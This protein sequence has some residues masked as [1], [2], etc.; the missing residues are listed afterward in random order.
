MITYI[1]DSLPQEVDTVILAVNYRRDQ[2]QDYIDNL[3]LKQK[4]IVNQ[5][6]QPLGTGGATK[7]A[8]QYLTSD[9]FFVLNADIIASINL[10]H[11]LKNHIMKHAEA[12]I[13]LWPVENVSEYGVV[14]I[15]DTGKIGY[16][17]EK[18][19][20]QD[21]PS[22][23]INAGAYLLEH[24]VLDY[25]QPGRLISME[26]EI[27]PRIIQDTDRFYGYQ[28]TGY[29]NDVGRITSYLEVNQLLLKNRPY[30]TGAH[31]TIK[32]KL[33]AAVVGDHVTVNQGTTLDHAV[34]FNNAVIG[35]T[36]SIQR[37]VI[38]EGARIGDG[39]ILED[40]AVGD[41]ET[42]TAHSRLRNTVVWTQPIPTGYP[43]KQIGNVIGE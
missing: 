41:H 30:L 37:S 32:G 9:R 4:I 17:V 35:A 2:I 24:D 36:C 40:V 10:E 21:A 18:P 16:F 13:S 3:H 26:K 27:F 11:M 12:S 42:V 7:Y 20:P 5:E 33:A 6:P 34:V 1:L 14:K 8:E 39:A 28:F 38:G 25:I 43:Q 15:D 22:N 19:R 23:L 29:W 31:C